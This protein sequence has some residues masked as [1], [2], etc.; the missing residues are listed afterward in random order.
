MTLP[1]KRY[2]GLSSFLFFIIKERKTSAEFRGIFVRLIRM[3]AY[4][5]VRLYD[6]CGVFQQRR[7][8]GGLGLTNVPMR[9]VNAQAVLSCLFV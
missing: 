7:L 3:G 6:S 4:E 5:P 2:I 9:R 1:Y 8:F